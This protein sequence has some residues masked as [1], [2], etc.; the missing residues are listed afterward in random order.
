[1]RSVEPPYFAG[2]DEVGR[3]VHLTFVPQFSDVATLPFPQTPFVVLLGGHTRELSV[4]L[5]YDTAEL[6]LKKGAVYVICWGDGA[7]RCED[8]VDEAETMLSLDDDRPPSILTTAHEEDTLSEVLE[9]ATTV[10]IPSEPYT[11]TCRDVLL[12]FHGNAGWYD[13]A[14]KLLKDLLSEGPD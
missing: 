4:D 11:E 9:F 7:G 8:I 12:V 14:R 6:L 3:R 1:M 13:E 2:I 5:I 10:A